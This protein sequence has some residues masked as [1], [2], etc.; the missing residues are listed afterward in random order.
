M[1]VFIPS[2]KR[3]HRVATL[4]NLDEAFT[5]K[6]VTLVVHEGEGDKYRA[7]HGKRV[8]DVVE[9]P[10]KFS[11]QCMAGIRE[12]IAWHYAPAN[13]YN[14]IVMLDDDFRFF[15]R[16]RKDNPLY[17]CKIDRGDTTEMFRVMMLKLKKYAHVGI[18]PRGGHNRWPDEERTACRAH[19]VIG[20]NVAK[21][22][23]HEVHFNRM[24]MFM[25]DFD[26]VL[27]LLRAGCPNW[28]SYHFAYDQVAGSN[29]SGGCST[30][31][32]P[33][34]MAKAAHALAAH[35]PGFVKVVVKKCK[36][37]WGDWE[38]RTDVRI[39]WQK[40]YKSAGGSA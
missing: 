19:G 24:P 34:A 30:V 2:H 6:W 14:R 17:L 5:R 38:E 21:L 18:A 20:F 4:D 16:R 33:E 35:H 9:V 1:Q 27:Q 37:S 8:R 39:Q 40:A 10:D 32:T 36:A 31:R 11:T 22:R 29:A 12:W 23:K 7:Y 25:E 15:A 13:E 28:V 26:V 3:A